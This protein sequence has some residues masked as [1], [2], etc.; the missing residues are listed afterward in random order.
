LSALSARRA[1]AID[2][3]FWIG[4]IQLGQAY[5]QLGNTNLALEAL[6][7]AARPSGGNSKAIAQRAYVLAK[8]GKPEAA[9]ELLGTLQAAASTNRYVPPYAI[10][11]IHAGLRE[12]DFALESL[13]RAYDVR[14]V[15]LSFLT[16][17]PKWDGFRGDGRFVDLLKRCG[18]DR[19][20]H[21][22]S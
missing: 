17:D 16:Y 10:A 6:V 14:D 2:P 22:A 3:E 4:Y 13:E 20:L 15:H 19:A 1:I 7:N 18:F 12:N 9:R 5:E 11:L 21:P 8:S